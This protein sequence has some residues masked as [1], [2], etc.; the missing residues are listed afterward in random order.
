LF[1]KSGFAAGLKRL[2]AQLAF[3]NWSPGKVGMGLAPPVAATLLTVGAGVAGR[4]L[5]KLLYWSSL[6]P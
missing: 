1:T 4:L 3:P 5:T 6:T 2:L